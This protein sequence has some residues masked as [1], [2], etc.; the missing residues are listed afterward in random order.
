[1]FHKY[2]FVVFFL[3]YLRS[4]GQSLVNN[5]ATVTVNSG[6]IITVVGN[7][8]NQNGGVFS[9]EGDLYVSDHFNNSGTW[10]GNGNLIFNGTGIQNFHSGS[11]TFPTVLIN[12]T[13]GYVSLQDSLT[14][15]SSLNFSGSNGYFYL[16]G[17]NL[18]LDS[19]STIS[20]ADNSHFIVTNG[21]GL[22]T[23]KKTGNTA[24]V[25]PIGSS[26]SFF[27][28]LT[29]TN[30]GTD[31]DF[32]ARV[33]DS[34]YHAYNS[35]G[36]PTG[37]VISGQQEVNRVWIIHEGANGGSNVQLSL[38]WPAGTEG[39]NFVR[40][41]SAIAFYQSGWQHN[42]VGSG[43]S[44][45]DPYTQSRAGLTQFS[46]TPYGI[47][48]NTSPLPL[49]IIQFQAWRTGTDAHIQADF[50]ANDAGTLVFI[51]KK[52]EGRS[53]FETIYSGLSEPQAL[54]SIQRLTPKDMGTFEIAEKENVSQLNFYR[55]GLTSP[56]GETVYSD[57]R[58]VQF[59]PKLSKNARLWVM[60]NPA[61]ESVTLKSENPFIVSISNMDGK[62]IG[63]Y[64]TSQTQHQLQT[65]HLSSGV[66]LLKVVYENGEQE[67]HKLMVATP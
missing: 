58:T 6:T 31:D 8:T 42:S 25:F 33:Q 44:G 37:S 9:N 48:S 23:R 54:R 55:L 21:I 1:M 14:I 11:A 29:L 39:T 65:L 50:I 38:Q 45:S 49:K 5:G 3:I 63:S 53:Q 60:P 18:T 43:A 22:L 41:N 52:I 10:S 15:S 13:G 67:L 40:G 28:P 7:V 59:S 12:K 26:S 19:G 17:H 30:S 27:N 62:Q 36:V 57:W 4:E 66:Y 64:T 34:V 2:C 46:F 32:S 20:G 61:K 24:S 51:E 16:N 47:G 56:Q 35:S